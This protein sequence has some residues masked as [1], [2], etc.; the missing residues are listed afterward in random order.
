LLFR[1]KLD[2]RLDLLAGHGGQSDASVVTIKRSHD[3]LLEVENPAKQIPC[4]RQERGKWQAA[5]LQEVFMGIF[6]VKSDEEDVMIALAAPVWRVD[7]TEH[8]VQVLVTEHGLA[9]LRG[10]VPRRCA[11]LIIEK[12]ADPKFRPALEDYLARGE[13]RQ[14]PANAAPPGRSL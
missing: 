5:Q 13:E 14:R 12:C 10:L 1:A 11:R 4:F 6:A 9:D 2:V 8:D 3:F 7:H